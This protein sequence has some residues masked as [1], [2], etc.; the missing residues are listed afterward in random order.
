MMMM[1][2]IMMM[3]MMMMMQTTHE[4]VLTKSTVDFEIRLSPM[5]G[6]RWSAL[7][8]KDGDRC[9]F[10]L[11]P[12][13]GPWQA[14]LGSSTAKLDA[15]AVGWTIGVALTSF[16]IA[17]SDTLAKKQVV[18]RSYACVTVILSNEYTGVD[19]SK[20]LGGNQNIGGRAGNN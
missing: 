4:G 5:H 2:L 17:L 19:V 18:E 15:S 13:D 10:C 20:I 8:Y 16:Q 6:G 14:V 1:M 12:A 11:L 7:P 3:M 9:R